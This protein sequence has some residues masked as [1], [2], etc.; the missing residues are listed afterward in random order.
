LCDAQEL[1]FSDG[2]PPPQSVIDGWLAIVHKKEPIAV[3]CV[4]G[5]GRHAC[6]AWSAVF[7]LLWSDVVS[8]N[9][10][11][12]LVAIALIDVCGMDSISAIEY[13]RRRRPDV[14]NHRQIQFLAAY[15][16]RSGGCCVML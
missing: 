7:F 15:K 16:P 1:P 2:S 6:K 4:A 11:P 10:A 3:H 9:R 13:V 12:M 8:F 5:L 14:F